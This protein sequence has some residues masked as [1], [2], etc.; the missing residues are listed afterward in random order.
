MKNLKKKD[1]LEL[2]HFHMSMENKYSIE[3]SLQ[4]K[5]HKGLTFRYI[6]N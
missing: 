6:R 4:N 2:K 1:D 5:Q 3:D